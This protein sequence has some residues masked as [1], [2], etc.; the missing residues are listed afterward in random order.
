VQAGQ[1]AVNGLVLTGLWHPAMPVAKN[2]ASKA[3]QPWGGDVNWRTA[4]AY[5]ATEVIVLGLKKNNRDLTLPK[6]AIV[7]WVGLLFSRE[8]LWIA[9]L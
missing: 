5:D 9:S 6:N 4:T 7:I 3:R 8:P 1:S 2:F